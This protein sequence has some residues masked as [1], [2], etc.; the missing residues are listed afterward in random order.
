MVKLALLRKYYA[1][2]IF[3]LATLIVATFIDSILESL[4]KEELVMLSRF[5]ITIIFAVVYLYLINEML[6]HELVDVDRNYIIS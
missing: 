5:L 3:F 4:N 6:K 1:I 2:I